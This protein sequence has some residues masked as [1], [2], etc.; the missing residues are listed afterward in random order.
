MLLSYRWKEAL[1]AGVAPSV[2]LESTHENALQYV[3]LVDLQSHA[4]ASEE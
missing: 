3:T 1:D 2:V 4:V